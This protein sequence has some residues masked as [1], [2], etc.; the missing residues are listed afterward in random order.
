MWRI[1]IQHLAAAYMK[2]D[3]GI[4]LKIRILFCHIHLDDLLSCDLQKEVS[5]LRS[6]VNGGVECH[7]NEGLA[8]SF[9]G[10]PGTFKWEGLHG[11]SSPLL[12]DRRMSQVPANI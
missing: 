6:L 11:L 7:E 5:R 2:L 3:F 9:P 1:S 12:S 4:S 10:S 8:I